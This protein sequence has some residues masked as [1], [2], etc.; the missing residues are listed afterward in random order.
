METNRQ[1]AAVQG[2]REQQSE[3]TAGSR[4]ALEAGKRLIYALDG[5]CE[6]SIVADEG[7]GLRLL[8]KSGCRG[9]RDDVEP[10]QRTQ[11]DG[12]GLDA[13]KNV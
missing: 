2:R 9:H 10:D 3:L 13:I 8:V 12:D 1:A 7:A 6:L 5:A 4:K 11:C